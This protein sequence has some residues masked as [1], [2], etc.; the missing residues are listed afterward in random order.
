MEDYCNGWRNMAVVG[1]RMAVVGRL[2]QWLEEDGSGWRGM[3]V[4]G[5][6]WQW[7]EEY[8]NG[9]RNMAVV[10]GGWQWLEG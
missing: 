7:L 4:V 6:L 3:A 5:G 9:C 1:G 10:V 2:R 8:G